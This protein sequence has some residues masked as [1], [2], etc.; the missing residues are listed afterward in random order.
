LATPVLKSGSPL[1][2]SVMSKGPPDPLP[3]SQVS[4]VFTTTTCA[5]VQG[6]P[7]MVTELMLALPRG[8][9]LR[10]KMVTVPPAVEHP[11]DEEMRGPA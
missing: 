6:T 4:A 2:L 8:P 9:K 5:F 10:P 7:L 3:N 11:A 1:I